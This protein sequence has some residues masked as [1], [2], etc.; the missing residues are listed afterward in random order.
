M[1]RADDTTRKSVDIMRGVAKKEVTLQ[2]FL[3][4]GKDEGMLHMGETEALTGK[5]QTH[6][7]VKK[8][9]SASSAMIQTSGN[10]VSKPSLLQMRCQKAQ[11]L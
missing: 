1:I 6:L 8:R 5:G 9:S 2:D 10:G 3:L 4:Q 11:I 7:V